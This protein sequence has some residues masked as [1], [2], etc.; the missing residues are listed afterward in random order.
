MSGN[1]KQ[2]RTASYNKGCRCVDCTEAARRKN[3]RVRAQ[4][5]AA[6]PTPANAVLCIFN[7]IHA[8][9]HPM[10]ERACAK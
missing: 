6:R 4:R 9:G 5:R 3:M 7:M 2:H 1:V 10:H 8:K